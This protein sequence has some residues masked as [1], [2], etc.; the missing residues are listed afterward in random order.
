VNIGFLSTRLAGTDGVSLESAKLATIL[1]RMGHRVFYCAG[2]LDPDGPDG[3]EVPEMHFAHPRARRI[4]DQMFI[5]PAPDDLSRRIVEMAQE[6]KAGLAAFRDRFS[7]DLLFVQNAL[8]I[9]MHVPLGV[10]V[11]EFVAQSGMPAVAHHHDLAWERPRFSSPALPQI[12]E[13][14]FPPDLPSVRHVAINSLAQTALRQRRG[15]LARVLPN[16]FDFDTPAPDPEPFAS[17]LRAALGLERPSRLVLQPTRVVPRKGIE[18][19]IELLRR[20]K[21]SPCTLVISHP[22]GDEGPE[23]LEHL[24][25]LAQ[26]SGVDLRYAAERFAPTRHVAA[27]GTKTY[28]LWDAYAAADFVTYPSLIEGFGNALLETI[29]FGLPALVN[30]YPVYAADIAPLGFR[31]VEID[32]AITDAAVDRTRALLEDEHLRREIAAHNFALARRHF[33]YPVGERIL[34]QILG[35]FG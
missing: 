27:D 22:A 32:G 6:L 19:A 28:S 26:R 24:E 3:L 34:E 31:F 17:D 15:L 30:R 23:Y 2:Q 10:A 13:R 1:H 16:L 5:G 11:A 21:D 12:L 20:L 35:E 25:S 8:A 29:Y 4:H 18:L 33:S 14:Y 9:P 7:I